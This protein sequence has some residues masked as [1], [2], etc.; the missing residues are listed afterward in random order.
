MA[1]R[2]GGQYHTIQNLKI[3][4]VDEDNGL[5]LVNGMLFEDVTQ[6]QA[7]CV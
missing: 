2:M 3:L 5:V 4:K 6:K 7:N 1:G